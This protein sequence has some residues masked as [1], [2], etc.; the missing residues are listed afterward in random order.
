MAITEEHS[1]MGTAKEAGE[2][3]R[4]TGAT[5]DVKLAWAGCNIDYMIN[6]KERN[7]P[8][9]D[10]FTKEKL[11]RSL[12]GGE[13][14]EV[15]YSEDAGVP[16]EVTYRTS[17]KKYYEYKI[18]ITASGEVSIEETGDNPVVPNPTTGN[19][20]T[21]T[22]IPTPTPVPTLP[23]SGTTPPEEG[24]TV[25]EAKGIVKR[26]GLKVH[27][28]EKVDYNSAGGGTWR[29]FYYDNEDQGNG[30]GYFGDDVGTVYLKRDSVKEET[31]LDIYDSYMPTDDGAMMKQMNPKWRDSSY[32]TIDKP[33]EH[34]VSWL[35]DPEKWTQYKVEGVANYAIGSPSVEMYMKSYNIYKDDDKALVNRIGGAN[36]YSI[37][38]N[39]SFN[40]GSGGGGGYTGDY[41]IKIGPNNLFIPNDRDSGFWLSSPC[42]TW[43]L[44]VLWVGTKWCAMLGTYPNNPGV[45][46][47]VVSLI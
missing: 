40:H 25:E 4:M 46:L 37:G 9:K 41:N 3:N 20:S 28:G 10:F 12:A 22:P 23:P 29:I 27:L 44:F 14:V 7:L 32:S 21:P 18:L 11:N 34:C 26:D 45:V 13:A 6:G 38:A 35:C 24:W 47:P 2:L 30:K 17:G 1:I 31:L 8:K 5:E 33:N 43:D 15:K 16:S 19:T 36:G 42:Q 39:G